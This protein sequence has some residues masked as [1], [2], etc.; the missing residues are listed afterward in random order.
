MVRCSFAGF[1]V[2]NG[3]GGRTDALSMQFGC[4]CRGVQMVYKILKILE[5]SV[6][7]CVDFLANN[8]RSTSVWVIFLGHTAV[9]SNLWRGIFTAL[10]GC[11][12]VTCD[13]NCGLL[14]GCWNSCGN[15]G[16]E[17]DNSTQP[18][19][20]DEAGLYHSVR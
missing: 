11:I 2:C 20:C 19:H 1:V 14:D 4:V 9:N 10:S 13:V 18:P 5:G 12:H 3:I 17:L 16:F 7:I 6:E 8:F 15:F